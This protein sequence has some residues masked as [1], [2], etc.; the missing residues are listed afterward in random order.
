VI[1]IGNIFEKD[2]KEL[3]PEK[4]AMTKSKRMRKKS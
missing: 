4:G 3:D 2:V 1:Y